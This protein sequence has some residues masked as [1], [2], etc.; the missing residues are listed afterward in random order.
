MVLSGTV[1]ATTRRSTADARTA[2]SR[3]HAWADAVAFVA[4]VNALILVLTLA[5]GVLLGWAPALA[6][7]V[8]CSRRRIRGEVHPWIRLFATTWRRELR[9]ATLLQLPGN[10][11]IA[12]LV[13]NLLVFHDRPGFTV[14]VVALAVAT[15]IAVVHQVLV[16][17][18]DAHYDLP[19]GDCLRLAGAF[20]V[21]FPGAPLLLA[22]TTALAAT[23]TAWIPGLLPV[24]A[25]GAWL[26]LC[27]ALCLSFFAANDRALHGEEATSDH[28]A[29]SPSE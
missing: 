10:V 25:L 7:A 1:A 21:R 15:G 23:V 18:M 28:L 3:L 24:I 12:L 4:L 14:L 19:I 22:A 9:R 2:T 17:T 26:Y 11:V 8:A 5:G 16:V 27:T 6:A 13:I 20:A 29:N